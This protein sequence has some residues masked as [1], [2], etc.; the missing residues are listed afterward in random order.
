M[1]ASSF[2]SIGNV[3]LDGYIEVADRIRRKF[4][5]QGIAVLVM[6]DRVGR[7]YVRLKSSRGLEPVGEFFVGTYT[8][9]APEELLEN[10]LLARQRELI[11]TGTLNHHRRTP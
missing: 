1:G 10:D 9:D 11:A 8:A 3:L 5:N 4:Q 2:V 7:A 6:V